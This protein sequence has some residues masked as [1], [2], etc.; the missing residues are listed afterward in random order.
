MVDSND[1]AEMDDCDCDS[2]GE[3]AAND[4]P[5]MVKG[6][7]NSTGPTDLDREF[8]SLIALMAVGQ[9]PMLF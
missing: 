1:V 5:S 7:V 9:L 2:I 8:I 6:E 4:S 3:N